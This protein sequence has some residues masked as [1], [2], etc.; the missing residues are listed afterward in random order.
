MSVCRMFRADGVLVEFFV[1]VTE[2]VEGGCGG[3]S[4]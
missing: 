1:D 4:G 2:G 3:G